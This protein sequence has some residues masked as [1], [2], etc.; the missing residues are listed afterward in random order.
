MTK[1]KQQNDL[2]PSKISPKVA[3]IIP[4]LNEEK[5]IGDSLTSL[6]NQMLNPY[7]IIVVNDGSTDKTEE[8]IKSF[9]GVEIV[10][11]KSHESY[12]GKKE[13]AY[14]F[15]AGLERLCEDNK[16]N[17]IMIL[18]SDIVLPNDYLLEIT[19]RMTE[20]PNVVISSGII[21][22]EYSITPR[23]AGRVVRYDFWKVLGLQY[24][25]NY[26]FEG[27]LVLKAKSLGYETET[28]NDLILTT[29][30]KT[31]Q[32]YNPKLYYYYG[33]AIKALGYTIP[34]ALGRII[35]FGKKNP[36]GAFKMLQ[37]F[38]SNYD[39]L[40]ELEL[41]QYVKQTQRNNLIHIDQN[42]LK[43]IYNL[44]KNS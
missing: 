23:G 5:I 18:G 36:K 40:Y 9:T 30:R 3:V 15:N 11:K 33:L 38:L 29:K 44:L 42:F 19:K 17:F 6:K 10:N 4:A 39:Q 43:K 37:G 31:G 25:V 26:G 13:L 14:T 1:E 8:V 7:R 35:I 24:P 34:Y 32:S 21:E 28:Y 12:V 16:C 41:R 2:S 20:N 22:G 27:Y